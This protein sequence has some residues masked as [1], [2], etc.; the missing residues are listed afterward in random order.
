MMLPEEFCASME[1]DKLQRA[2]SARCF[3][4]RMTVCLL[5][6]SNWDASENESREFT[7]IDWTS[8]RQTG[9]YFQ[10]VWHQ[11]TQNNN[12]SVNI[13]NIRYVFHAHGIHS[14]PL[15]LQTTT[16]VGSGVWAHPRTCHCVYYLNTSQYHFYE[17][18]CEKFLPDRGIVLPVPGVTLVL[19][20]LWMVDL[21]SFL[22]LP[23]LLRSLKSVACPK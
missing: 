15:Q 13:L 1:L 19:W 6:C 18:P 2:R 14:T 5:Y 17:N 22:F 12:A 21:T 9:V 3:L 7:G 20:T 10:V 8:A 4:D 23:W 16:L 11:G